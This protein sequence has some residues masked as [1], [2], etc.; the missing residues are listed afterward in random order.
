MSNNK[1]DDIANPNSI[2]VNI[3]ES[4]NKE[5]T[6][7]EKRE[8]LYVKSN[9]DI[10]DKCIGFA[11]LFAGFEGFIINSYVRTDQLLNISTPIEIGFLFIFLSLFLNIQTTALSLM[12]SGLVKSGVVL[13]Q[14]GWMKWVTR[15][16]VLSCCISSVL[17]G[18]AFQLYVAD[19]VV[20]D[21][22]KK[23]IWVISS[24]IMSMT[25][26]FFIFVFKKALGISDE[27]A[28]KILDEEEDE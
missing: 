4:T 23:L 20:R 7:D 24:I 2:Q 21:S 8:F 25:V 27:E 3:E 19:S 18:L 12:L 5:F 9:E 11:G 13:G 17:Y 28:E 15:L 16:C 1:P 6:A 14:Y 10:A 26:I 22:I